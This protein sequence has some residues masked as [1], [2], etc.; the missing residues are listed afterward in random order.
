MYD[1]SSRYYDLIYSFKDYAAEAETVR[2]AIERYKRSD[3]T[4]LLDVAC[5][6]GKHLE[7]LRQ[8]FEVEGLDQSE[9]MVSIASER[10]PDVRISRG[11]MRDFDLGRQFDVITCLFSAIGYLHTQE[12]LENACACFARHLVPGGVLLFEPWI[13]PDQWRD[14]FLGMETFSSDDIKI[15]R[16][17][18]SHREGLVTTVPF[19]YCVLTRSGFQMFEETHVLRMAPHDDYL[20]AIEL[21]GMGPLHEPVGPMGRGLYVG[22]R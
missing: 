22:L 20:K 18:K 3:G 4:R 19:V 21:A 9:E 1:R 8:W 11:D 7:H 17:S 6:T 14:G 10:L 16:F 15:A 5:G 13:K 12:A 2:Q